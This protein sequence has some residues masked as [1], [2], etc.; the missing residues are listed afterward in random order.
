[1]KYFNKIVLA[2]LVLG[3][4]VFMFSC[5]TTPPPPKESDVPKWYLNPQSAEDAIY[6]VGSAQMA[7]LD[8]SRTFALQRARNDVA[9]QVEIVVKRRT[10]DYFQQ[11]GE[12]D[13]TQV[14][15]YVEDISTQIVNQ[16]LKG[17]RTKAVEIGK[18]GTVYALVEY[19]TAQLKENVKNEFKRIEGAEYSEFKANQALEGLED[20]LREIA[21]QKGGG[22]PEG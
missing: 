14:L 11:G 13:N 12:I 10:T 8:S 17:V 6:G 1:M 21:A 4:L 20:D 18:D 16:T 9:A 19:S 7:T 22:Q 15:Q 5:A 2:F 3:V